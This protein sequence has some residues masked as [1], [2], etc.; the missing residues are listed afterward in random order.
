MIEEGRN[1]F[2]GGRIDAHAPVH[3]L[4]GAQDEYVPWSHATTVVEMLAPD[5]VSPTLIKNGDHRLARDE[6]LA[7][8]S[9]TVDAM[10]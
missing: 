9:A 1:H 10:G 5:P 3:I 7:S 8:L 4:I 6:V 2:F